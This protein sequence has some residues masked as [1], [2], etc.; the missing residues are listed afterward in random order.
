MKKKTAI[1]TDSNSGITQLQAK[2]LGVFVL[3]M[4]FYINEEL[5]F[6]DISLSQEE[7]YAKLEEGADISTSQP[8]PGEVMDMWDADMVKSFQSCQE[9]REE[10]TCPPTSPI[11][12]GL[13]SSGT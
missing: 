8:S 11:F 2:E 3:P 1:V 10:G 13:S 5:F 9:G 12:Q 6:E 7:F 4:P